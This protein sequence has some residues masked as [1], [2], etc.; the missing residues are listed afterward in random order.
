MP[1]IEQG[2]FLQIYITHHEQWANI[3]EWL[4]DNVGA[5]NYQIKQLK[6]S[7]DDNVVFF[8][9]E[10]HAMAFKLWWL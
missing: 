2:Y 3:Y 1:K 7:P 5:G 9:D 4:H 6:G 10:E 8:K